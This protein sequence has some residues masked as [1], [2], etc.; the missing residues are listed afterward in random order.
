MIVVAPLIIPLAMQVIT[1]TLPCHSFQLP[2]HALSFEIMF[3]SL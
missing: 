1:L 3:H 2:F